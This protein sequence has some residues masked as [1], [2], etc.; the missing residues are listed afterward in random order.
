MDID[1]LNF[2]FI[3]RSK[4]P[5][6]LNTG[7]KEKN[8]VRALMLPNFQTHFKTPVIKTVWYWH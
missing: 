7:L 1:K 3:R 2:K 8:K 5:R 4:R 6:I